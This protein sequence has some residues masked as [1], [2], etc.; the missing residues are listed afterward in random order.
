[1]IKTIGR[2]VKS[3]HWQTGRANAS[4]PT[5]VCRAMI[6]VLLFGSLTGPASAVPPT[7]APDEYERSVVASHETDPVNAYPCLTRLEDDRLLLVWCSAPERSCAGRIVG[8][9]SHD[10]GRTWSKPVCLIP[11]NPAPVADPSIVVC[12]R[13]ILVT[14]TVPHQPIISATTINAVRSD[15]NGQ[16]WS[17]PYA[18]PMNHRYVCGKIN[19]GLHLKSGALLMGYSWDEILEEEGKTLQNES[20]MSTRAG[21]MLSFDA[22]LTWT[23][24]GDAAATC[25]PIHPEAGRGTVEPAIVELDDGSLFMLMRTGTSHLYQARSSDEGRSWTDIG[26]SPLCGSNAPASLC[27]F[28]AGERSGILCV[29]DNAATRFPLC[30]SASFDGGRTWT[31]PKEI[32]TPGRR[33]EAS[34]PA[35]KQAADGTL[36]VVW[37]E[38]LPHSS[39]LQ[40]SELW[41][42]RFSVE[43]LVQEG[44]DE[45]ALRD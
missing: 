45:M 32:A 33:Q 15:D 11:G 23:N 43:W 2:Q 35:C 6:V 25:K 34:Y 21:V 27:N 5:A 39:A 22:G 18:I 40:F 8:A 44:R 3:K 9:Y 7:T 36:V 24:G 19:E 4:G 38:P 1:M 30:A 42:A 16:T 41:S 37:Q 29:W 10:N 13:R 26:P 12:G 17:E 31:A 28:R 14:G 20:Q